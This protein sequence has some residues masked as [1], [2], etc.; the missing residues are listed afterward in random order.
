M[1]YVPNFSRD[2]KGKY[3]PRLNFVAI[4][5]GTDAYLL[6][7][8][9]NE[10]QWIQSDKQ[11]SLIRRMTNSGC[12]QIS[13]NFNSSDPGAYSAHNYLIRREN[14]II[15]EYIDID[16]YL[17]HNKIDDLDYLKINH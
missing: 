6:E 3:D 12:L 9:W 13:N 2:P 14:E 16:N 15:Q 11:A 10:M 8:E 17:I 7:D 1:A 5:G 4:K